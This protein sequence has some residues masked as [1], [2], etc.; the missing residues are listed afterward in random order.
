MII[1]KKPTADDWNATYLTSS[2]NFIRDIAFLNNKKA[3]AAGDK[4]M[5]YSTQDG[6]ENWKLYNPGFISETSSDLEDL[7]FR[8]AYTVAFSDNDHGVVA[9]EQRVLTTIDGGKTWQRSFDSMSGIAVQRIILNKDRTGWATTSSGLLY[10]P[11]SGRSWVV[12]DSPLREPTP[13]LALEHVEPNL[14]CYTISYSVL[15][16]D[17]P[18]P[19]RKGKVA[20]KNETGSGAGITS[21]KM[22]DSKRG[23]FTTD[24]GRIYM[25]EDGGRTWHI[26]MDVLANLQEGLPKNTAL[27]IELWDMDAGAERIFAAGAMTKFKDREDGRHIHTMP[28]L[29]SWERPTAEQDAAKH[30]LPAQ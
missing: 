13:S 11:D 9:G 8:A 20:W 10:T 17:E 29:L 27:Q 12:Q 2:P 22:H 16:S 24:S 5:I 30:D 15:C 6:G 28:I 21:M 23:W 1:R 4:G 25:T 7:K 26:W 3:F 14:L 19:F 18:G